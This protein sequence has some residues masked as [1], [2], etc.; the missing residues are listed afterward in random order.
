MG[1]LEIHDL[2]RQDPSY[3]YRYLNMLNHGDNPK[4]DNQKIGHQ[5]V[6]LIE[7]R[8]VKFRFLILGKFDGYHKLSDLQ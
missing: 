8:R 4:Y 6:L 1:L 5:F 2:S 7:L 3:L